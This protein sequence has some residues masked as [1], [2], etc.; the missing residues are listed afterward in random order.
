MQILVGW[1]SGW[2]IGVDMEETGARGGGFSASEV[3]LAQDRCGA[4]PGGSL[5]SKTQLV[6]PYMLVPGEGS[7]LIQEKKRLVNFCCA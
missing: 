1:R 5:H 2:R 4:R 6:S 7:L 3:C